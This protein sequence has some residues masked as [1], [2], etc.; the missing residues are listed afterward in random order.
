MTSQGTDRF[1]NL[2]HQLP[3]VVQ[4]LARKN[5][6][7]W[8]QDHNYPSLHFKRLAGENHRFSVRIGNHYRALGKEVAGGVKWVWIG[9]HEEYNSL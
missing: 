6:K 7:L 2:Y 4:E 3:E 5:Y 9:T 8:R 1:W